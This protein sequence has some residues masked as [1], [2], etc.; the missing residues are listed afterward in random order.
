MFEEYKH[1]ILG[2]TSQAIQMV[3]I[4]NERDETQQR[5][6]WVLECNILQFQDIRMSGSVTPEKSPRAS[7]ISLF[8]RGLGKKHD[9]LKRRMYL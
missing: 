5:R 4:E 2:R 3:L 1:S 8:K 9:F 6:R 7:L